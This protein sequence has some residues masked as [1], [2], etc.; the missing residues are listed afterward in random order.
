M[1]IN[2]INLTLL[3]WFSSRSLTI[4]SPF[5][6]LALVWLH[7]LL[8]LGWL[9]SNPFNQ[10]WP[11]TATIHKVPEHFLSNHIFSATIGYWHHTTVDVLQ[12]SWC[13]LSTLLSNHTLHCTGSLLVK[14]IATT[15]IISCNRKIITGTI[16]RDILKLVIYLWGLYLFRYLEPEYLSKLI[17]T[18]RVCSAPFLNF[19]TTHHAGLYQLFHWT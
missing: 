19:I 9:A 3:A 1:L 17:E 15:D 5:Q 11:W 2:S 8:L 18:V 12:K 7:G 4:W 10:T 14:V 13:E 6:P 16:V